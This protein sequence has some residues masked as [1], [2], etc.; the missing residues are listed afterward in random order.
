MDKKE[1]KYIAEVIR[2]FWD[3]E[4]RESAIDDRVADVV[5]EAISKSQACS[6]IMNLVPRPE[7]IPTA[8]YAKRILTDI[9]ARI[10]KGDDGDYYI[11]KLAVKSSSRSQIELSLVGE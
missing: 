5:Y 8:G 7:G 4:V 2:Y 9:G 11:C 1:K 10:I 3:I 6:M